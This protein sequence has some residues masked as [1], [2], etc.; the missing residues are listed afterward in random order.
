MTLAI[1]IM[2]VSIMEMPQEY[3]DCML[4]LN[5]THLNIIIQHSN[6]YGVNAYTNDR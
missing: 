3:D 6:N 5:Y 2:I 1:M 4:I